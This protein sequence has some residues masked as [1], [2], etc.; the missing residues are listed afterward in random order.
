MPNPIGL[1]YPKTPYLRSSQ[2]SNYARVLSPKENHRLKR[3]RKKDVNIE[4]TK[5]LEKEIAQL[6]TLTEQ[7]KKI[8][9]KKKKEEESQKNKLSN[10]EILN[11]T[12]VD[13]LI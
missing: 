3:N 4:L 5:V 13:Y 11:Q 1:N 9:E 10:N 8:A 6:H 7:A 12:I 2:Y